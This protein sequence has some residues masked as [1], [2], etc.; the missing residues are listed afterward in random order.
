MLSPVF[1]VA[2]WVSEMLGLC[3]VWRGKYLLLPLCLSQSFDASM[4]NDVSSSFL[5]KVSSGLV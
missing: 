2:F 1:G 5:M 4:R 3:A